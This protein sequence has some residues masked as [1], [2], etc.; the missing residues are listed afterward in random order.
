[1]K[2][3]LHTS[4]LFRYKMGFIRNGKR[5]WM[6]GWKNNL[7]LDSGLDKVASTGWCNAFT[8]CLFGDQVSPT[9]VARND[10]AV[11]F[12]QLTT[13]ITASGN[14]FISSDTGRLFKFDS[15]EE[16]YLTFVN[17]TTATA[18]IS[19]TVGSG[20]GTVWYVNQTALESLYATTNTYGSTGGDNGSSSVGNVITHKRTYVGAPV[21]GPVTLTEIG[22]SNSSSNSAIFDRDIITGGVG[23][24]T[25][26][27]PLA[28]AELISTYSQN[29][30]A[31]VGNVGT[32]FDSSGDFQVVSLAVGDIDGSIQ[33]VASNGGTTGT[34][35]P[36]L[37]PYNVAAIYV[38]V[39]PYS[40]PAFSNGR[41]GSLGTEVQS[42]SD[43]L[44]GYSGGNFFR[45]TISVF[46]I[47]TAV[48]N[49]YGFSNNTNPT[50]WTLHL[51]TLFNKTGLQ[52]L[53]ITTRK[54][55][56]RIL[57]N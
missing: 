47:A 16:C 14:F 10:G 54:S 40:I 33:A 48:G 24:V 22:F 56:Q 1:M 57:T 15:G 41:I 37:E 21:A 34:I 32:G 43:T 8:Y 39:A 2:A 50:G 53:T 19:R 5:H 36:H 25:G 42:D 45:D 29:T 27:I 7:I 9:P 51:T 55:W 11:S 49:I 23:L 12:S 52:T 26:D 38:E 46:N 44:Q 3:H 17:A 6:T 13:V 35:A 30:S 18:S 31:P 28:V 20:P 4:A